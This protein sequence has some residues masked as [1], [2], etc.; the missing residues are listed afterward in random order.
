MNIRNSIRNQL[1]LNKNISQKNR[2]HPILPN[3]H[4]V[5]PIMTPIHLLLVVFQVQ[6]L[7]SVEMITQKKK[8]KTE[9]MPNFIIN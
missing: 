5:V 8:S 9:T 4:L 3:Y 1:N 2:S 6:E 7:Q